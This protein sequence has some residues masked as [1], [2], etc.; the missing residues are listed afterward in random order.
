MQVKIRLMVG[1]F[2]GNLCYIV[3]IDGAT[4][5]SIEEFLS[6]NPQV[7]VL[8]EIEPYYEAY[9]Y[10]FDIMMFDKTKFNIMFSTTSKIY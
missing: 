7:S 6:N 9:K 4:N 3:F 2:N 5:I 8:G 1:V 10:M